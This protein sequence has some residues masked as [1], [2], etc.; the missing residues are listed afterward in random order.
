LRVISNARLREFWESRSGDQDAARDV[1]SVWRR[2]VEQSDWPHFEAMRQTYPSADLVGNC[3][4]FDVGHNRY[5][6]IGR[7]N[8]ARGI[9]YVL[10]VMDHAEYDRKKWIAD[11]GCHE[12]PSKRRQKGK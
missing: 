3:V 9:V 6:V 12:P 7:V 11:C 4:V 5:R 8:F 10:S 1:L 2:V